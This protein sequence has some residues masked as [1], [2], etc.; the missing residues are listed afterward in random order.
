MKV[1][2]ILHNPWSKHLFDGITKHLKCEYAFHSQFETVTL[3]EVHRYKPDVAVS[4]LHYHKE[5]GKKQI[6]IFTP[7]GITYAGGMWSPANKWYDYTIATSDFMKKESIHFDAA[8]QK[9]IWVTGWPMFDNLFTKEVKPEIFNSMKRPIIFYAPTGGPV[10]SSYPHIPDLHTLIPSGATLIIKPHPHQATGIDAKKIAEENIKDFTNVVIL[11]PHEPLDKY[12]PYVDLVI[13][14]KSTALFF[15]LA[16]PEK[17]IIQC[18]FPHMDEYWR[19]SLIQPKFIEYTWRNAWRGAANREEL[20]KAIVE[21]LENP[22][23]NY[24]TRKR[25]GDILFGNLRD[26]KAGQRIA[27]KIMGLGK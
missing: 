9:E 14:E 26:G 1:S 8:P 18:A 16:F 21:E 5:I 15:P 25:Y 24:Q 10:H 3:D 20:K 19:D 17:P 22:M 2:F 12:V 4:A 13:S 11:S 23:R 6:N 7:H 27:E